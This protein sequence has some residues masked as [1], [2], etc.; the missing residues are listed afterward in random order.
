MAA[1]VA[2]IA[3]CGSES[4]ADR[5]AFKGGDETPG[6]GDGVQEPREQNELS[7]DAAAPPVDP[8]RGSPLCH[9]NAGTCDPDDDGT[10]TIN[11]GNPTTP[12]AVAPYPDASI[13]GDPKG[14]RLS[15]TT[16]T[17]ACLDANPE[18]ADGAKCETG[19]DCAPGFDCVMA[20]DVGYCRRYCCSGSCGSY[21]SQNGAETFCD[22]QKLFGEPAG[23]TTKAPVCM[24]IK[25][26]K[27]FTLDEC[28]ENE[29]CSVVTDDGTTGCVANGNATVG[30]SC[31]QEHC[32]VGLTCLGQAGSRKC[33]QLCKTKNGPTC[34][35]NQICKTSPIFPD[36]TVGFCAPAQ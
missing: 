8:F 23:T 35:A 3:A 13:V 36:P 29:T 10:K 5:S 1:I 7:S 32:S 24:P 18:N 11:A 31:D 15:G 20:T 9:I 30:Q 26:C 16:A 25:T 21:R 22:V 19:A 14:C 17:P 33:L 12:C 34:A 4:S 2:V 6:G 28:A 27:L